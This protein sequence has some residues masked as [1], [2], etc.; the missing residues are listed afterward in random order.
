MS[1]NDADG[2]AV[3]QQSQ[4]PQRG[5]GQSID[6]DIASILIRGEEVLISTRPAWSAWSLHLFVAALAVLAS[7]AVGETEVIAVGF[8]AAGGIV[9]YVWYQRKKVRYLVTDRRLI[10]V[11]GISS[12]QTNET[13]ME[14]VRGMQTGASFIE[15]F[16]GHGHITVSESI[17]PRGSLLALSGFRGLTLGGIPDY[18][19]IANVVRQRQA[20]RKGG[21]Y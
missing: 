3:Q 2:R 1:R 7:L 5:R 21:N 16:L 12:K 20:E 6:P 11:T 14:D 9:G 15:R 10:V 19:E 4:E 13:W 18:E 8:L 17:L